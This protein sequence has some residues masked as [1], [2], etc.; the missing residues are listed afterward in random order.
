[1][2]ALPELAS[3]VQDYSHGIVRIRNPAAIKIKDICGNREN[4]NVFQRAAGGQGGAG[5]VA[6]YQCLFKVV[7]ADKKRFLKDERDKQEKQKK[8]TTRPSTKGKE[9]SDG[10]LT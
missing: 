1:M 5:W 4:F 8:V 3:A 6:F 7:V 2:N 10:E 9:S